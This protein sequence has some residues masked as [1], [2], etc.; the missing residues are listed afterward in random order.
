[1]YIHYLTTTRPKVLV[2]Q[3]EEKEDKE[4]HELKGSLELSHLDDF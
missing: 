2:F 4:M 3:G 1:M